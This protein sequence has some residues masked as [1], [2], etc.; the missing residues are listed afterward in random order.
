[1][2]AWMSG[3]R[4]PVSQSRKG[5]PVAQAAQA[6]DAPKPAK[7][8]EARVPASSLFRGAAPRQ[9]G[10]ARVLRGSALWLEQ[11]LLQLADVLV[12]WAV[13]LRAREQA[14]LR[15]R[16][17]HELAQAERRREAR[18]LQE[19]AMAAKAPAAAELS[20]SPP[21]APE[22]ADAEVTFERQ[23]IGGRMVGALYVGGDLLC[24]LP[25]VDRH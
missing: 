12:R 25:D 24:R 8:V 11:G 13:A 22:G 15:Q 19:A 7:P 23:R 14:R 18:A 9:R 3:E 10:D 6:L 5:W 4:P 16:A 2:S 17:A 21:V 1:M 20:A